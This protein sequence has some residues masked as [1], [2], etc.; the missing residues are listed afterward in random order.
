[1]SDEIS[2]PERQETEIAYAGAQFDVRRDTVSGDHERHEVEYLE[3]ADA[4]VVVA[5]TP[6]DRILVVEEW[7]QSVG[8]FDIGLPG[9]QLEPTDESSAAAARRELREETGYEA[10]R[11]VPMQSFDP[12]T[13]LLDST[14]HFFVAPDCRRAGEPEPDADERI[15]IRT[16]SLE[17]LRSQV[18]DG[19]ITDMKTAVAV[20]YYAAFVDER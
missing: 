10:D 3:T 2:P 18:R 11:L 5:T 17:S 19:T 16:A 9:G 1:M 13:S 20:L 14:I 4:V 7:R 8:R 6:D 12:L 15:R